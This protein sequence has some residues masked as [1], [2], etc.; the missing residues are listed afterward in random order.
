M[1]MNLVNIYILIHGSSVEY[2]LDGTISFDDN[3]VCT[4]ITDVGGLE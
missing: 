3:G 1:F 2:A 4:R